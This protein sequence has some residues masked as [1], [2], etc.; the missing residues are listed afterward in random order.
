MQSSPLITHSFNCHSGQHS[1]V[2]HQLLGLA[3]SFSYLNKI[4][5][6]G[7]FRRG[8]LAVRPYNTDLDYQISSG[9]VSG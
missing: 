3:M 9:Y 5:L 4:K 1:A 6:T 7:C 8:E 2:S